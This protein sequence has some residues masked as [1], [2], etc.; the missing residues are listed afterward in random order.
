VEVGVPRVDPSYPVLAHQYRGVRIVQDAPGEVWELVDHLRSH[1][2]MTFRRNEDAQSRRVEYGRD[3]V[4]STG[5][6]PW[7]PRYPRVRGD[8]KKLVED[9]PGYEPCVRPPAPRIQSLPAYVEVRRPL[10]CRVHED[11]G[12]DDEHELAVFHRL[13]EGFPVCNVHEHP[14]AIERGKRS[15]RM[16]FLPR[17]EQKAQGRLHEVGHRPSLAQGLTFEPGHHGIVDVEGRLHMENHTVGMAGCQTVK[18]SPNRALNA[19]TTAPSARV[20]I[21]PTGE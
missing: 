11:V 2:C 18:G 7:F 6:G 16:R 3:E 5:R 21:I 19:E 14:A 13:V 10:V 1:R 8:P 17:P 4:P 20:E 12:V 9:S 15:Q